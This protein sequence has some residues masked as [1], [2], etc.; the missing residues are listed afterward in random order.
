MKSLRNG[1]S[2][3]AC[4][5][6]KVL[7]FCEIVIIFFLGTFGLDETDIITRDHVE[8]TIARRQVH[9][10]CTEIYRI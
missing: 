4:Q 2:Q 9:Y 7:I 1:Q 5:V 6:L 10:A 3:T 8:F